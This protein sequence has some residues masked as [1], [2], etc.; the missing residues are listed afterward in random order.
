[1][2]R[3]GAAKPRQV[4]QESLSLL[5]SPLSPLRRVPGAVE[6]SRQG[7]FGGIG[8][9]FPPPF[10][11]PPQRFDFGGGE[12]EGGVWGGRE[13]GGGKFGGVRNLLPLLSSLSLSPL[14]PPSEG[15]SGWG[16]GGKAVFEPGREA[17]RDSWREAG[18]EVVEEAV[19]EVGREAA[20]EEPP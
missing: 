4:E 9:C 6:P 7:S 13:R 15:V 17:G 19:E 18:R 8:P 10:A 11:L 14:N 5:S 20:P 3:V 1:M 16:A 12:K 2:L